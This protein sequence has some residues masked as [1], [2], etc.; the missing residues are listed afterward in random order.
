MASADEM[1]HSV[2]S[3]TGQRVRRLEILCEGNHILVTG[4][5]RDWETKQ[6]VTQAIRSAEPGVLVQNEIRIH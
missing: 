6:L 4:I 3:L 2:R 1:L 5:C